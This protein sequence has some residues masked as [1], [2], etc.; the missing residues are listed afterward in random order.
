M[1]VYLSKE[2]YM[3]TNIHQAQILV[4][5]E[6]HHVKSITVEHLKLTLLTKCMLQSS[7]NIPLLKM[8]KLKKLSGK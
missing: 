8:Q 3:L 1:T 7:Q 5:Q 6:F 2:T 4:K